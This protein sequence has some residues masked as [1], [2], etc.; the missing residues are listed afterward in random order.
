MLKW[1]HALLDAYT[2]LSQASKCQSCADGSYQ[3]AK[4]GHRFECK[5]WSSCGMLRAPLSF[6]PFSLYLCLPGFSPPPPPPII[7]SLFS[8]RFQQRCSLSRYF[9]SGLIESAVRACV[10]VFRRQERV[11]DWRVKHSSW[12]VQRVPKRDDA[13]GDRAS[14]DNLQDAAQMQ[15]WR[16]AAPW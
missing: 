5:D 3:D 2:H 9:A 15:R 7:S 1:K 8:A 12:V 11:F 14:T 4:V 6:P 13:G 16:T 10:R